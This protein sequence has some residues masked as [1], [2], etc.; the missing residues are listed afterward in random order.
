MDRPQQ[1]YR[2]LRF[3]NKLLRQPAVRARH[4]G[5][6]PHDAFLASYPRSGT[7]WLRFLLY[8]I[9]TGEDSGFGLMRGAIPSV[10]KQDRARPVLAHGGRLIQTH[11]PYC[12]RDRRVV[13]IV[14][15][16]RSVV[17]SE[18]LWQQRSGYFAGAFDRFVQD[19]IRG[20]SNPWGSWGSHLDYWRSSPPALNG[21]LHLLRYEDL[22]ADTVRVFGDILRFFGDDAA[23]ATV[24]EHNSLEQM[25]AKEDQAQ[26]QGRRRAARPEIRFVNTGTT[27][28]WR[29]RLDAD[30]IT[31]IERAFRTQL[32]SLGY[33]VTVSS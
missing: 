10:G 28:G 11:E 1:L 7:T 9:L 2:R 30:Q 16:P 15:D 18:Y 8:E 14:R 22:R 5:L 4:Q 32:E 19:F 6:T 31:A 12:D 3:R 23:I 17:V 29:E 25:R 33:A 20:R 13:Y 26:V 24:I 27:S 21:H